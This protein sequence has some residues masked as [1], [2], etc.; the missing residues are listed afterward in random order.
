MHIYVD[1][2][3]VIIYISIYY[4][5]HNSPPPTEK[6][7]RSYVIIVGIWYLYNI[8]IPYR[9][10]RLV[11]DRYEKHIDKNEHIL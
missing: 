11:F 5:T 3:G 10:Y 1:R 9:I 4:V 6:P 7:L 2:F 8:I